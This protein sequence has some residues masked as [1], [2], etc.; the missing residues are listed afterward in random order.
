MLSPLR[1][2][3]SKKKYSFSL[4]GTGA[5]SSVAWSNGAEQMHLFASGSS[6]KSPTITLYLLSPRV[7][8][9]IVLKLDLFV[10]SELEGY[11]TNRTTH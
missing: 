11:H 2:A 9:F 10:Y 1:E 8:F 7:C 4:V 6:Q 3:F 5:L